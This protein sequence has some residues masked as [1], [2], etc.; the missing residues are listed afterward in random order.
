MAAV[1]VALYD[2]YETADRVR[3]ELVGDGFPTD[4][5][6]LTSKREPG[7]AGNIPAGSLTERMR[8][9][10]DTLFDQDGEGIAGYGDF[11]AERVAQGASSITVH[12]R[13]DV[14][15]DRAIAILERH[16]PVEMEQKGLTDDLAFER[17]AIREDQ[18][19]VTKVLRGNTRD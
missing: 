13:G 8:A 1:L 6:E 11:F 17:A 12:P 19:I 16:G 7:Q 2:N 9:Y 3:T 14:E 4:R 18:P 5:V 15:I 10:F